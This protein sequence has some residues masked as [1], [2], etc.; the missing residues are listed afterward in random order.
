PS[1]PKPK[2]F[3]R[4]KSSKKSSPSSPAARASGC[5]EEEWPQI[6]QMETQIC[7]DQ[8]FELVSSGGLYFFDGTFRSLSKATR[9]T[10]GLG[11]K[12]RSNP[13]SMSV[14]RSSLISCD[15]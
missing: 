8:T 3:R 12:F 4:S 2:E 6:T 15:S 14:A 7:A 11:P 9:F 10:S 13:T 1:T 5:C